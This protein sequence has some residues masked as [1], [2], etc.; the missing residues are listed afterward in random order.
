MP[1]AAAKGGREGGYVSHT[2]GVLGGY[3]LLLREMNCD[4]AVV[5]WGTLINVSVNTPSSESGNPGE[6]AVLEVI[7]ALHQSTQRLSREQATFQFT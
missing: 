3:G 4:E 1:T 5:G 2:E 6:G 7:R